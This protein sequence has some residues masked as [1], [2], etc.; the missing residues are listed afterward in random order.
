MRYFHKEILTT[1][2]RT[3][4]GRVAPFESVGDDEGILA[5]ESEGLLNELDQM[6][7]ARRAGVSEINEQ[8]YNELKKKPVSRRPGLPLSAPPA[9]PPPNLI[10]DPDPTEHAPV[11]A[12]AKPVTPGPALPQPGLEPAPPGDI[13]ANRPTPKKLV[14][15]P[16][17]KSIPSFPSEEP[18]ADV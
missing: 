6:I 12:A 5:T 17:I 14:K 11:A 9:F 18:P 7:T 13:R 3:S 15:A 16:P 10:S 4:D 8:S 2:A 1:P